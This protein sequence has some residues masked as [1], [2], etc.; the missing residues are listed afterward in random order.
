F[1]PF[2]PRVVTTSFRGQPGALIER[3]VVEGELG[4]GATS[5]VYRAKDRESGEIV[6]IK[7]LRTELVESLSAERF[8]REVRLTQLLTHRNI[9]PVLGSGSVDG[10]LYCVFRW[11]AG[12]T[13]RERLNREKQ[14]PI[15][16]VLEIGV[17]IARAL[18]FAH[19]RKLI[20]RDVKPENIL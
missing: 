3:Y 4:S 1:H 10:S 16:A 5:I 11:M 18:D 9:V 6:A 7:V 15:D 13:L 2:F 17:Q 14:L 8:L 19:L 12:G 20:H